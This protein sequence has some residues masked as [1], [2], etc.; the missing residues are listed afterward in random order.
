MDFEF[1]RVIGSL[2]IVLEFSRLLCASN[3]AVVLSSAIRENA[4]PPSV[5][6]FSGSRP[7]LLRFAPTLFLSV[8][9]DGADVEMHCCAELRERGGVAKLEGASWKVSGFVRVRVATIRVRGRERS[10]TIRGRIRR[11]GSE[12]EKKKMQFCGFVLPD[13]STS[14]GNAESNGYG[15][16]RPPQSTAGDAEPMKNWDS[17]PLFMRSLPDPDT[18]PEAD[19]N[20]LAALQS[21]MFDDPP[22]GQSRPFP[23]TFHTTLITIFCAEVAATLKAKAN[24]LFAERKFRDAVG[25]YTQAIDECGK[26]LDVAEL[27]VLWSNRAAAN[28]E[29]RQSISLVLYS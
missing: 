8:P 10:G 25:F 20:T 16:P 22:S 27:R 17:V 13:M 21:L 7:N 15:V 2:D 19:N 14:N 12:D 18:A 29:L 28:L 1:A 11:K 6:L 23:S 5:A 4:F 3:P 26:D 9:S 24:E